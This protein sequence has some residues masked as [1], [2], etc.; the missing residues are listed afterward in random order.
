MYWSILLQRSVGATWTLTVGSPLS[1][2]LVGLAVL[3]VGLWVH[4]RLRGD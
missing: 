4:R 2:A 3:I 1:G